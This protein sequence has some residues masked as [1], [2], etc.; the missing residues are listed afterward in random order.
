[1][2]SLSLF[3]NYSPFI[4]SSIFFPRF[5]LPQ[6]SLSQNFKKNKGRLCAYLFISSYPGV[7]M[8]QE[9]Y[10]SVKDLVSNS[11]CRLVFV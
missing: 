1:M 7:S 8:F 10:G 4:V 3:K 11:K 6:S 5:F 2:S 9:H